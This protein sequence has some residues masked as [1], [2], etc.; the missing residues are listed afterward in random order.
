MA[1]LFISYRVATAAPYAGRLYD[2][3]SARFGDAAIFYDRASLGP[4]DVWR[5][6][7]REELQHSV[8]VLAV[9]DPEWASMLKA[10]SETEDMVR[11]ELKTAIGLGKTIMLLRVAGANVPDSGDLP[12]ELR[13]LLDRQV[14]KIDDSTAAAYD[15]S[16]AVLIAATERLDG[17]AAPAESAVVEQLLAKDYAAAERLLMRQPSTLRQRASFQVYLAL[18]RLGDRSFNALHPVERE[19]IETLLR[20]ARAASSE[21]DLAM[22]LLAILEI[23]FYELHGRASAE[24]TRTADVLRSGAVRLEVKS[25]SLLSNVRVSDRARRELRLD[26]MLAGGAT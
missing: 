22:L 4:G 24:P 18:A 25:R 13:C 17:L 10:R 20:R 16:I 15:A 6:R 19:T 9:V 26:A 5:D 1:L 14:L 7:L 23:D 12:E 11:F 8:A 2:R 21:P 3:L